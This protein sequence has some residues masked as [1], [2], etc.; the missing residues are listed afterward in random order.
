M[1][2]IHIVAQPNI[3][4]RGPGI[5][6][7]IME[8]MNLEMFKLQSFIVGETIPAFFPDGAPNIASTVT[9]QP[10]QLDGTVIRGNVT[11]GGPRTTKIT[12]KSGAEVDYAAVQEFGIYHEYTIEPFNK[13]ALRFMIQGNAVFARKVVHPGLTARPFM[14]YGLQEMSDE[15][16]AG[17]QDTLNRMLA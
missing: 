16:T 14:E 6:A 7:A 4:N 8:R 12:L 13:K 3:G 9:A 17:L 5:I 11:A 15:I 10:A 1:F 2:T